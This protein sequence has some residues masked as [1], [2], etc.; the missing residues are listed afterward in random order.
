MKN[1]LL[2]LREF[3]AVID[4]RLLVACCLWIAV[5]TMLNYQLQLESVWIAQLDSRIQQG[6]ALSLIY[7]CAFVVP[8][9]F[10]IRF[11]WHPVFVSRDFALLLLVA[12]LLFALK[13][14]IP[15]P[16]EGLIAGDW[17]IYLTMVTALP[18][19]FLVVSIVLL[20]LYRWLPAQQNFWGVTLSG[21]M[22]R[23]YW[24][25]L[26]CMLPLI[27]FAS[28]QADFLNAYPRMKQMAFMSS[29]MDNPWGYRLLYELGY[30]IDFLT[31]ELFFRGFLIFAFIRYAG[32]AAILPMATFYCSIH[33]GKPVLECISSFAGGLILG[34][35]AYRTRSI[36]GGLLVHLGIAWM[37]EVGGYFGSLWFR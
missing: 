22:W 33:F 10:M 23:P 13:V 3:F 32:A 36:M 11:K 15:N 14:M 7:G 21:V 29:V 27:A 19:K 2:Y 5:L 20:V 8:Y 6:M 28:T 30:G 18:F 37:M 17:G 26:L 16:L 1:V 24:Q 25:M 31:I 9:L 4:R 35:L 34:V 12:P